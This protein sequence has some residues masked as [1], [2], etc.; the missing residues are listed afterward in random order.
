M[1]PKVYELD[2]TLPQKQFD[3]VNRNEGNCHETTG[4]R[5][6]GRIFSIPNVVQNNVV[7]E[8]SKPIIIKEHVGGSSDFPTSKIG[9]ALLRQKALNVLVNDLPECL[10]NL[11][12]R[13]AVCLSIQ[14]KGTPNQTPTTSP[15]PAP[16]NNTPSYETPT[17]SEVEDMDVD[18]QTVT[19]QTS[20]AED[21][22]EAGAQAGA[23][24][25]NYKQL[26][27]KLTRIKSRTLRNPT[28]AIDTATMNYLREFGLIE[29]K[30]LD[31]PTIVAKIDSA[32]AQLENHLA[33]LS[34]PSKRK[35]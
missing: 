1:T 17:P 26:L 10:S 32:V 21:E 23:E 14:T 30:D 22:A 35:A 24:A 18:G 6:I 28:S 9:E 31:R 11:N 2:S 4:K 25:D 16:T 13:L 29:P 8:T 7:V 19:S 3:D 5:Y 20:S 33:T 15:A 12:K 34:V 27:A